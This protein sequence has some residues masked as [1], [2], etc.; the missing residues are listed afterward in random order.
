MR[1]KYICDLC[2]KEITETT[3]EDQPSDFNFHSYCSSQNPLGRL[4][5]G[6]Q[7]AEVRM[8]D[9]CQGCQRALAEAVA[10]ELERLKG[11]AHE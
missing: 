10:K 7:R 2:K 3:W 8:G 9:V 5:Y 6:F 4:G 1:N 11:T